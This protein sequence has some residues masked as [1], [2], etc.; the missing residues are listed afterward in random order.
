MFA[1]L[2]MPT[3]E[4][5]QEH[6]M[7]ELDRL[8]SNIEELT[9]IL[10]ETRLNMSIEIAELRVKSGLWGFVAGALPI[11]IALGLQALKSL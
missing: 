5:Y 2:L 4:T 8:N 10:Q 6:V 3:W 11:M 9:K 1:E 7:N